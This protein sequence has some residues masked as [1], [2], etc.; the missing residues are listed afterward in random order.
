M[1]DIIEFQFGGRWWA[2][3]MELL[4][5]VWTA[6][7]TRGMQTSMILTPTNAFYQSSGI[8]G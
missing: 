6:G 3:D 2:G 8:R 1:I 7:T 5:F 4:G